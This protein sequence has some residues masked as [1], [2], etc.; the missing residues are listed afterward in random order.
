VEPVVAG[1]LGTVLLGEDLTIPK[2]VGGVLVISG[3]ALAQV[4]L[5]KD[6]FRSN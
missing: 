2:V 6:G 5:G 4:R 3:A 1:T